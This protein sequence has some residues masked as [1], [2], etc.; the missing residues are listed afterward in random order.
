MKIRQHQIESISSHILS[1]HPF[2]PLER[3]YALIKVDD[4]YVA[5]ESLLES[6]AEISIV[7]KVQKS[8]AIVE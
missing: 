1:L 7:R 3:G 6:G 8:S 4:K 2:A 5:K